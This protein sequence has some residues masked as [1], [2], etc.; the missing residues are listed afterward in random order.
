LANEVFISKLSDNPKEKI[1]WLLE[2]VSLPENLTDICIKANLNDYRK[3]ETASTCD[4][5]ILDALL[6]VLKDRF[7]S[8]NITLIENDAT[9]VNADNIF[10]YLGID[11][12]AKKY[13]CICIN[14]A[15]ESWKTVQIQGL[16][17]NSIDIPERLINTFFI[18]FPKLKSHSISKLMCGLNNQMWREIYSLQ[19][20]KK[21]LQGE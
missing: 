17:F 11:S 18:T 4:P 13:G 19:K 15:R 21:I 3:W 20:G 16:H 14:A 8:S 12:I 2:K 10:A 7:P 5:Y 1:S 6:S 9:S